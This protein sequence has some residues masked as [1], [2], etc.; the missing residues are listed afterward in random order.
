MIQESFAG[1]ETAG[2]I[3][4]F[5]G[6]FDPPHLGHIELSQRVAA[7]LQVDVTVYIPA[8]NPPHKDRVVTD[9]KHRLKMLESAL[10]PYSDLIISEFETR[11]S[12]RQSFTVTTLTHL[13]TC[14]PPRSSVYLLMG[15][16][17]AMSFYSWYQPERILELADPVVIT[18]PPM[19]KDDIVKALPVR[20]SEGEREQWR[21]RV[22]PLGLEFD[23]S[24]TELRRLLRKGQ[25]DHP[26]VVKMLTP[27]TLDYIR[28]HPSIYVD[29]SK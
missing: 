6:T 20:L 14:C 9:A 11:R 2:R 26:K 16:D 12:N 27:G 21:K 7:E 29:A 13:R 1:L 10:E 24:S 28:D 17:M 5:G 4:V 19:T 18:R 15:A 23:V 22:L 3:L 25:F 8:G